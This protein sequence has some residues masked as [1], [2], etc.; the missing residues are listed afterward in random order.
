MALELV[1]LSVGTLCGET[2]GRAPLLGTPKD[3]LNKDLEMGV[4]LHRDPVLGNM[5][6]RS[7]P[8]VFE[9]RVKF[10]F[11]SSTFMR[12]LRDT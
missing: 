7:F 9:R 10:L 2:G 5:G 12:N 8:R 1:H 6:G 4:C 11:I 3:L